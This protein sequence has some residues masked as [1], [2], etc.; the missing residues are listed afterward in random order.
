MNENS[1]ENRCNPSTNCQYKLPDGS[2]CSEPIHIDRFCY[3]HDQQTPKSG[4]SL[5]K[6]VESLARN[7]K[8]TIGLDLKRT[9]LREINLVNHHHKT[10][11]RFH[12][13]DFYRADMRGSHLF[14][15]DLSHSSLM[16]ADLRDANLHCANL[17]NVN[18]L[19]VKWQ[20]A[21]IQNMD[22]G[23][24]IIQEKLA[25]KALANKD[26]P[27]AKDY[28]QQAEEIYRDLRKAAESQGIFSMAGH[29]IVKELTMRRYQ[30]P[31]YSFQRIASKLV[32]LFCGYGEEPLKVVNFSIYLIM[33]CAV[34]YFFTGIQYGGETLSFGGTAS[35]SEQL[36]LFFTCLYYSVVT[37]TTLGYGDITP[38]GISRAIAAI[39]AFIGSFTIALF[40][41]VFVKKMTR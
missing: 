40:V 33:M 21:K 29:F 4:E 22:I 20:G 30:L 8:C 36:S 31:P 14:N 38:I 32:D 6:Q 35:Y 12:H 34:L 28:Y 27:L 11:F 5:A 1:H 3:F 9:D 13:C 2:L 18:L 10:G 25:K 16:K 17:T 26:I 7:K 37:F 15:I 24:E 41:V 23:T 39:Q 19:G